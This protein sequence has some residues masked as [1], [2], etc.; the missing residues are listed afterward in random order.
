[1]DKLAEYQDR[2]RNAKGNKNFQNILLEFQAAQLKVEE[3]LAKQKAKEQD[4]LD[5]DFKARKAKLKSQ[6][7]IK[8]SQAFKNLEEEQGAKMGEKA[9]NK[10]KI[11]EAL[12]LDEDRDAIAA[13]FKNMLD[14]NLHETQILA[15]EMERKRRDE[16]ALKHQQDRIQRK[17]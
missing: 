10:A 6:A 7:E 1:M 12:N 13:Q 9:S 16:E 4:R 17:F 11:E 14:K 15:D 8:R 2:L 3:E 5:R